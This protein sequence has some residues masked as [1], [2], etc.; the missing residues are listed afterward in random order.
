MD[1]EYPLTSEDANDY[2]E[3]LREVRGAL[4]QAGVQQQLGGDRF[5]LTLAAPAREEIYGR[6]PLAEIA[7]VVDFFNLMG[8]DLAGEDRSGG[9]GRTNNVAA[10]QA[11]LYP[12]G[13]TPAATPHSVDRAVRDYLARGVPADKIVLGVPAFGRAFEQTDGL[14]RPFVHPPR[15]GSYTPGWWDYKDLPIEGEGGVFRDDEAVAVWRYDACA[16]ELISY[17]DPGTVRD[18]V[19]YLRTLGLR[20]V[21]FWEAA[22]DRAG[23]GSLVGA[24]ALE[25]GIH[26]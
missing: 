14:G 1:W 17:D 13:E 11:N 18:K 7:G 10:H 24:S 15:R 26:F 5:L 20:G 23:E 19:D 4:D 2:L 22:G 6:F 3:L 8:Y 25:L 12:S 9:D 16:R 21:M